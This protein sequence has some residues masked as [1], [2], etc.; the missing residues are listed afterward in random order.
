M[1]PRSY[2]KAVKGLSGRAQ[3]QAGL[4]DCVVV[5]VAR[6]N[7]VLGSGGGCVD[8]D[9]TKALDGARDKTAEERQLRLECAERAGSKRLLGARSGGGL[10]SGKSGG[11]SDNGEDSH[12]MG[13][14]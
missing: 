13:Y 11:G 9:G 10:G 12:L 8:S 2:H 4:E 6:V 7:N 5:G 14:R 1:T 3:G